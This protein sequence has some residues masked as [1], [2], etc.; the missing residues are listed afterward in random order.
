MRHLCRYATT[1]VVAATAAF[2]LYFKAFGAALWPF[3]IYA[4]VLYFS[5]GLMFGNLNAIAME[6]MGHIAGI[7]SAVIGATSS[8]ISLCLGALI[9]QLYDGTLMPVTT[10]FLVLG[11]ACFL[12]LRM[13]HTEEDVVEGA[14]A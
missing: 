14:G 12:V 8:V 7:A 13:G 4:S 11:A 1:A 9:G 2:L 3:L 6:P 10:G 5:M